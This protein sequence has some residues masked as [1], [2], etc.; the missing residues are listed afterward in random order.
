MP[1]V[2]D[3]MHPNQLTDEFEDGSSVKS[4]KTQNTTKF[5]KT[6]F[7]CVSFPTYNLQ[8][9]KFMY[10]KL[11]RSNI[12]QSNLLQCINVKYGHHLLLYILLPQ[13]HHQMEFD[14][15]SMNLCCPSVFHTMWKACELTV[16]CTKP[17]ERPWLIVDDIHALFVFIFHF[18][19]THGNDIL[20]QWQQKKSLYIQ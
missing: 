10:V 19:L 6:I 12:Y 3:A 7:L 13:M 9:L 18:A 20:Y 5:T 11:G 8:P 16:H 1:F 2:L 17:T 15:P 4:T 14:K